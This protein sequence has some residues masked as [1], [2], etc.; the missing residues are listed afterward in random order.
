[1]VSMH[2]RDSCHLRQLNAFCALF[3]KAD[4]MLGSSKGT[5][6]NVVDPFQLTRVLN[7]PLSSSEKFETYEFFELGHF[8]NNSAWRT[9][10]TIKL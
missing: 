10:I 2:S 3:K 1:M 6:L 8:V 5:T 4:S 9:I 7:V